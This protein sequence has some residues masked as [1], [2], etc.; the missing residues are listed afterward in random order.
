VKAIC[1]FLHLDGRSADE[2]EL[3]TL[4][5]GLVFNPDAF[6]GPGLAF[7][8]ITAGPVAL[9]ASRWSHQAV[10]PEPQLARHADSGCIAIVDARLDERDALAATL[11]L[12]SQLPAARLILHAWLQWGERCVDYLR[13][14][15]A[16]AVWDPREQRLFCARDIMGVRP[17]YVHHTP[18]RLFAFASR[19]QSLLALPGVPGDL[20]EGRIADSLVSQLESIDK[21]STLFR[22]VTRL[23]PAHTA[24]TDAR[25]SRQL[26]Y[27]R[28]QPG[29][30]ALPSS[31][32]LWTETFANAL[33]RAVRNHL[34]SE[35]PVG[36]MVSGGM[37][38]SSLA[39]IARDQLAAA[40]RGPLATFSS[41]DHGPDCQET[42]A[43]HAVLEQPGFAPTLIDPDAIESLR[44]EIEAAMWQ[45]EEP[46]DGSMLLLHAQ[47]LMAARTGVG[48]VMDGVD[49]DTLLS[50][51]VALSR[52]VGSLH[53]L[54]AWRNARGRQRIYPGLKAGK[55]MLQAART[56]VVPDWLRRATWA[57]RLRRETAGIRRDSLLAADFAQRIDLAARLDT[58]ARW[59]YPDTSGTP[60]AQA[61]RSADHP[62]TTL[63]FER[64]HRVAAWHGVDPRHPFNDLA[65]MELCVNLPD[66]QRIRDGWSKWVLR[67]AMRG[68]LPD[69]VCWRTGKEHLGW[70]LIQ[71]LLLRDVE[72]ALDRLDSYR[73]LLEPYLDMAKLD[74]A[75]QRYRQTGHREAQ[76]LVFDALHLGR[77]LQ[78]QRPR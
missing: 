28:L 41:I 44:G 65:V 19:A 50:E 56:A 37:D 22:S 57:P 1:G 9:G 78:R 26:R 20:D 62:N 6:T 33:E 71:Q 51:G 36:C 72:G 11:G 39:V 3:A 52:Q 45:S 12:S 7:E 18:G 31:D 29:A 69:P 73:P 74:V 15:F 76:I 30:V 16:L 42:R 63:G 61:A 13:G 40:G 8:G 23:P 47:Y 21:T 55:A 49:A 53:W 46:F 24:S 70:S 67:D 66:S 2:R 38:S 54:A 35:A 77:W 68:R 17:L 64:Y 59:H 27:W 34:D 48:A 4:R 75:C 32:R 43:I 10:T 60:A 14:D 58:H 5:A 25:G